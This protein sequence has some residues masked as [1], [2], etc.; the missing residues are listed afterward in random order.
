MEK[1]TKK[2]S[3]IRL[4]DIRFADPIS[5]L[6]LIDTYVIFGTMM[7]NITLYSIQ[8]NKIY[9]LS[10]LSSENIVDISYSP[11][12]KLIN[13]AIG[14]EEVIKYQI[15]FNS[16]SKYPLSTKVK[17]YSTE[18]EHNKYCE[19]AF[20][21]L[22]YNIFFRVQ[23]TQPEEGNVTITN[24]D[25]EFEIR[26]LNNN[27]CLSGT[28]PMTNYS[29]PLDFDSEKF[30][31]VEFLSDKERN[32]CIVNLG[33]KLEKPI[34][35]LLQRS[36]GHISHFKFLPGNK[37]ILVRN[38]NICE[39]RFIDDHFTLLKSFKNFGDEVYAIDVIFLNEIKNNNSSND[40]EYSNMKNNN[41]DAYLNINER[42]SQNNIE[43]IKK[44]NIINKGTTNAILSSL[45]NN[46][47]NDDFII[48]FLDI[49]GGVSLYEN[50]KIYQFFN[51]YDI[52]DIKQDEKNK[53]F[54]SM[55]YSYYIRYNLNYCVISSDHGCYI[56]KIG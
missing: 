8:D 40:N 31:W 39:I 4:L 18:T 26:D 11:N 10:E 2:I 49:D 53:K 28:L 41:N 3:L 22:S 48:I 45:N 52:K 16:N 37:F 29:V 15:N 34:K 30:S 13:V 1:K 24:I 9:I 55:G 19:N 51:L 36:F 38:L 43:Q 54:F 32:L 14:D 47:N 25:S 21:M 33:N 50:G 42:K 12:D 17:N 23:L 35:L 27:D 6:S 56:L 5:A 20:I 44:E 7:G 46:R